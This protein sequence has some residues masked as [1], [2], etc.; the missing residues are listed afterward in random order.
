MEETNNLVRPPR[1]LSIPRAASAPMVNCAARFPRAVAASPE[2]AAVSL[3]FL[4]IPS[5]AASSF[6]MEA[7]AVPASMLIEYFTSDMIFL[8]AGVLPLA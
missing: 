3:P 5:Q 1:T 7:I 8:L 4:F 2:T 6:W